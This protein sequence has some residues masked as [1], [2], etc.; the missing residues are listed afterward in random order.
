MRAFDRMEWPRKFK[1]KGSVLLLIVIGVILGLLIQ[2]CQNKRI[3]DSVEISDLSFNAWGNQYI[4]LGY[5]IENKG[6][7]PLKLKLL[8]KVWDQQEIELASA[9]FEVEV[10]AKTRQ[11]RSKMLD[12]LHRSLKEGERPGRA[13]ISLYQ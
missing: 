7:K 2:Q 10:P 1:L 9:L 4:E 5:D 13:H 11:T 12:R 6:N 8:A 3:A